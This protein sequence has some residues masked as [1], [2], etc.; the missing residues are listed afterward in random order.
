MKVPFLK[1]D[2]FAEMF[3]IETKE[4]PIIVENGEFSWKENGEPVLQKYAYTNLYH[5]K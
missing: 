2:H 5:K 3:E 4:Y 1:C